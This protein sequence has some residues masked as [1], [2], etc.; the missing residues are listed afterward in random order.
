VLEIRDGRS[1]PHTRPHVLNLERDERGFFH[2]KLDK[3]QMLQQW[4]DFLSLEAREKAEH[5]RARM[6][7]FRAIAERTGE[8]VEAVRQE[9]YRLQ[10]ESAEMPWLAK[11]TSGAE[12]AHA[13]V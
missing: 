7:V 12:E 5:F 11:F 1:L 6:D 4:P 10:K 9:F 13:T 3:K 2:Y 8:N